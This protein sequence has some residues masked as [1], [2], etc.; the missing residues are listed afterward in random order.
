MTELKFCEECYRHEVCLDFINNFEKFIYYH[1]I[2]NVCSTKTIT[3]E[4]IKE[5][6][7]HNCK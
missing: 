5:N 1:W 7:G 4:E 6:D 2:C 3:Y